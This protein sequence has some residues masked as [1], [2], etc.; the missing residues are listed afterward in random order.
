MAEPPYGVIWECMKAVQVVPFL[1][2]GAS[3]TCRPP[4][5]C[6]EGEKTP[7]LPKSSELSGFLA[8]QASFP[9]E[10]PKDKNDLAKV[11]SYYTDV[12][13]RGQLRKTLRRLLLNKEFQPGELHKFLASVP[14]NQ[15]IVTTNYD[16][17]LEQA[18]TKAG[19]PYD[20]VIYPADRKDYANSVLWWP[21][22]EPEGK[23]VAAKNLDIDFTKTTV[24]YKMH[25]TIMPDT[26]IW[27]NFVITEEDYVEFLSRMTA[28]TA[29][30]KQINE[31]FRERSFLFLGYSLS[32]WN[33]R[34]ILKNL[35]KL[36]S[37][38]RRTGQNEEIPSWAIQFKPSEL[39]RMLWENRG[40]KIFDLTLDE[41]VNK[42]KQWQEH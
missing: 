2:S 13:G 3:L 15:V 1:G 19:R 35:S 38:K 22:G 42:L 18:L 24:I 4:N 29:V 32:D 40:V 12:S 23:F 10:D 8:T 41:F 26:D 39:E 16:T 5:A 9:S 36:F 6:W 30:P 7:F 17:L 27:D 21:Y 37:S 20:L 14:L 11:C 31:Y 34:V 25:G 33:L 28:M